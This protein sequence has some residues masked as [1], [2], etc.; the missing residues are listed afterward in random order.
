MARR[1]SLHILERKIREMQAQVAK[2]K[3]ADKPGMREVL[4]LLKKHGLGLSDVKAALAAAKPNDRRNSLKPRKVKP[5]YR[6]PN[7]ASQLWT[8]RGKM[9]LW[10]ADLV[11]KGAKPENFLI[12]K[13]ARANGVQ[14][15]LRNGHFDAAHCA[16]P[17][18][19]RIAS[20][21]THEMAGAVLEAPGNASG[22]DE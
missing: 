9:P 10:M 20:A 8:G 14:N 12:D 2:L 13:Q 21:Y 16:T 11:K 4:A 6:N 22:L 7:N 5:K 19:A 18:A 17:T 3:Q 1:K 15:A